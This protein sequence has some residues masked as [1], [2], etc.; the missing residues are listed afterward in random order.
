MSPASLAGLLGGALFAGAVAL[1]AYFDWQKR[2]EAKAARRALVYYDGW[3]DPEVLDGESP[4]A[5]TERTGIKMGMAHPEEL[6]D[7]PHAPGQHFCD[8]PEGREV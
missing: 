2:Q 7:E 1:A 6:F 8:T 5:Y 4:E 3:R